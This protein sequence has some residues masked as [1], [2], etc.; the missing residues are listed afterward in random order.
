[1]NR[2][3][4]Q[5]GVTCLTPPDSSAALCIT[6]QCQSG[7][8]KDISDLTKNGTFKCK[9]NQPTE[10]SCSTYFCL[11]RSGSQFN[12]LGTCVRQVD[13]TAVGLS[14]I[15]PNNPD[16][17]IDQ[18]CYKMICSAS[19]QCTKQPAATGTY[20][21]TPSNTVITN[22]FG[23]SQYECSAGTCNTGVAKPI[24]NGSNC[25]G[26]IPC[27]PSQPGCLSECQRFVCYNGRCTIDYFKEDQNCTYIKYLTARDGSLIESRDSEGGN[28]GNNDCTTGKCYQGKC[29]AVTAQNGTACGNRTKLGDLCYNDYCDSTG[30]CVHTGRRNCAGVLP[31]PSVCW[32]VTCEASSG[33]CVLV[34]NGVVDCSCIN[35]CAACTAS[36]NPSASG[37]RKLSCWWC[38]G[39]DGKG[40][41]CFNR[42]LPGDSSKQIPA[43]KGHGKCYSD[44]SPCGG[45]GGLTGG[46]VAGIVV[47]ILG[48]SSLA[49]L[50]LAL[51][52]L[53]FRYFTAAGTPPTNA[54]LTDLAF[55]KNVKNNVFYEGACL[56]NF[57]AVYAEP[58]FITS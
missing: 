13:T 35:D 8:C 22:G 6:S 11:F 36:V 37:G 16:S 25:A 15:I 17:T 50:L 1:V 21:A 27:D 33:D 57:S 54:S 41:G 58:R 4:L 31:L 26:S 32:D 7:V 40:P 55:D 53:L 43:P 2:P 20:C 42:Y 47:G 34:A 10:D 3:D 51:G 24:V 9:A 38:T 49:A 52:A 30:A 45:G 48:L 28:N 18:R 44:S 46:Q 56:E 12:H 14:C 39:E 23:C 29:T 19:G 5:D